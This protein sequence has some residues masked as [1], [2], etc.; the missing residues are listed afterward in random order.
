MS[1]DAVYKE[2]LSPDASV[3]K[4]IPAITT[5][6]P[7]ELATSI[8]ALQEMA[9]VMAGQRGLIQ[10]KSVRV[11]DL[12]YFNE[13]INTKL[14]TINSLIT[15]INTTILGGTNIGDLVVLENVG[16]S[17]GLPAVDGSQLTGITGV[18]TGAILPYAASSAPT[19]W[20]EC[21]GGS[22]STSTY[23]GLYAVIG[24][25]YGGSGGTFYIPDLRGQFIRGW[26]HGAGTDP[27]ASSRTDRGDGTTGDYVGTQQADELASHRHG[28]YAYHDDTAGLG[29]VG[30]S[31]SGGGSYWTTYEGGNE[32]RPTNVNMMY[33]IKA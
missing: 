15:E 31:P 23:A 9:E 14:N 3:L 25:T 13:G 22:Y 12:S 19:G 16:G 30:Y 5:N 24:Y 32:T 28:T 8:R 33:I 6:E 10:D 21:N 26:D 17:A 1:N 27:D 2:L 29:G 11:R 18:P 7:E 20:L 4:G